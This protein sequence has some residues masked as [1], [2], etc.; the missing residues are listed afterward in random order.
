LSAALTGVM[1]VRERHQERDTGWSVKHFHG[2]Y[3][4]GCLAIFHDPGKLAD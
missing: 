3:P 2:G 4:D 1:A